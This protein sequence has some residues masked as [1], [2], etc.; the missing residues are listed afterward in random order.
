MKK[1]ILNYLVIAALAVSAACTSNNADDEKNLGSLIIKGRDHQIFGAGACP[2]IDGNFKSIYFDD[3]NGHTM[4]FLI[5]KEGQ[6]LTTKTYT[7]NEIEVLNIGAQVVDGVSGDH[8][9]WWDDNVVME[10]AVKGTTF[11]ITITGNVGQTTKDEYEF[12]EYTVTYEGKI[13][14]EVCI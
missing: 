6:K 9:Y 10:V 4:M 2:T 8:D 13:N 12:T 1:V 14:V 7:E 11:N 5:F 3:K